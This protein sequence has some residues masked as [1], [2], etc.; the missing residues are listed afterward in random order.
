MR[1]HGRTLLVLF[2]GMLVPLALFAYLAQN[3]AQGGGFAF[4][5][6]FEQQV[7]ATRAAVLDTTARAL[8]VIG[9]TW[10][11]LGVGVVLS[12]ALYR[13]RHRLGWFS[14]SVLLGAT[15]LANALRP[16]FE[17]PRPAGQTLLDEP[18]ASFPSGHV[19]VATALVIVLSAA[20][21]PTRARTL[22]LLVGGVYVLAMM[23]SRV[24]GGVHHVSDV[25][26]SVLLALAW[27]VGLTR[28]THAHQ[29]LRPDFFRTSS[30][31]S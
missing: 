29:V 9:G 31:R 5:R 13:I 4:E 21:W 23:W 15:L 8:D 26:A 17:R 30:K 12:V 7:R 6:T 3:V 27:G 20:L 18:G 25:V 19:M 16:V 22:V 24:Y 28:A 11:M 14:L 1:A 10:V 2:V